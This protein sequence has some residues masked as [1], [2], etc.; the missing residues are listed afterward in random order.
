MGV[1]APAQDA[2][3]PFDAEAVKAEDGGSAQRRD[4]SNEH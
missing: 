3:G 4:E 1:V 2:A